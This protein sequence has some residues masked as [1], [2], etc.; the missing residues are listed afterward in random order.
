MRAQAGAASLINAP[1]V[2]WRSRSRLAGPS[3]PSTF[4]SGVTSLLIGTIHMEVVQIQPQAEDVTCS[5][6]QMVL[7]AHEAVSYVQLH[8]LRELLCTGRTPPL[9]RM[10]Q[11]S[12]WLWERSLREDAEKQPVKF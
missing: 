1:A 5:I 8:A 2:I 10:E 4:P 3:I 7:H 6:L 12:V 11:L 9:L